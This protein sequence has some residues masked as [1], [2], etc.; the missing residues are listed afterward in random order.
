MRNGWTGGQYS[1]FRVLLAA[2][3][4]ILFARTA[5]AAV[6]HPADTSSWVD[7]LAWCPAWAVITLAAIASAAL[8]VGCCDT[9]AVVFCLYLLACLHAHAAIKLAPALVAWSVLLARHLLVP[10]A[11]FGSLPA[12]ARPD[13]D[14]G[15]MLPGPLH[16]ATWATLLAL[17]IWEGWSAWSAGEGVRRAGAAWLLL[18]PLALIPRVRPAA[19]AGVVLVALVLVLFSW[20]RNDVFALVFLALGAFDPAWIPPRR[21]D[22]VETFFYDGSCG[23]CH[24]SVRAALAEDRHPETLRFAPLQGETFR[25]RYDDAGAFPDSIVLET[26][27]GPLV[28]STATIALCARFGGLWRAGA[29]L[30]GLLPRVIRDALYDAVAANRRRLFKQPDDACPVVAPELRDRFLD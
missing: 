28:K 24:R 18:V 17:L 13:P 22:S 9:V 20:P 8:A 21:A 29:V 30:G 14:G 15:W 10:P 11:P 1:V 16:F 25:D 4:L 2:G 27:A 19:W 7:L 26:A 23:L 6:D 5:P 3:L 12:C